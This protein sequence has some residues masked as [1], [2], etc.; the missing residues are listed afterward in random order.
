MVLL[1]PL[2]L[3]AAVRLGEGASPGTARAGLFALAA[4]DLA[5]MAMYPRRES[6]TAAFALVPPLVA[7][8]CFALIRAARPAPAAQPPVLVGAGR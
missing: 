3:L 8:G 2:A 4:L 6:I 7:L 1:L 5:L